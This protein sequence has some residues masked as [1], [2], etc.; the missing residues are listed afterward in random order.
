MFGG[1]YLLAVLIG[2]AVGAA[3]G[4]VS[5]QVADPADRGSATRTHTHK[6][7]HRAPP[8]QRDASQPPVPKQRWR[9]PYAAPGIG[10]VQ[11]RIAR[12]LYESSTWQRQLVCMRSL[13]RE[14]LANARLFAPRSGRPSLRFFRQLPGE[15]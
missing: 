15:G 2:L 6:P 5:H 3:A 13:L 14:E 11:Q 9:R 7:R 8:T 10:Q 1:R 4:W 12:C